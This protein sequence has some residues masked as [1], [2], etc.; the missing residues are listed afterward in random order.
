MR[1]LLFLALALA[2]GALAWLVLGSETPGPGD[3]ADGGALSRPDAPPPADEPVA[4]EADPLPD[5]ERVAVWRESDGIPPPRPGQRLGPGDGSMVRVVAGDGEPTGRD[6]LRTLSEKVLIRAR[7]SRDLQ[8]LD[9]MPVLEEWIRE[10]VPIDHVLE[11]W[12]AA[13]FDV[14]DVGHVLILSHPDNR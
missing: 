8:M 10:E 9:E 7:S 3:D 14:Q 13:G 4:P 11:T 5:V 6:V 1:A 12:R 2:L